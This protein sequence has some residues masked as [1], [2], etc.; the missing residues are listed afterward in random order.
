MEAE[1]PMVP[2]NT[3]LQA[4]PP[5]YL[6]Q[7]GS[8]CWGNFKTQALERVVDLYVRWGKPEKAER[9]R[10]QLARSGTRAR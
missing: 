6:L 7:D 1:S 8:F 2:A 9:C 4:A 3:I 5:E 10:A